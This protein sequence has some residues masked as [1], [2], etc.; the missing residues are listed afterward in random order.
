MPFELS[1]AEEMA[2]KIARE[3]C[4]KYI[5][6]RRKELMTNDQDMWDEEA[7]RQTRAGLHL[8]IVPREEGGTGIGY[9]ASCITIEELCAAWPDL[10]FAIY[11]EFAYYFAK[12]TGGDVY[13]KYMPGILKGDIL[14]TP[15]ITEPS[16]GSDMLGLQ[17]QAKKVDGGWV[18]NGRKV[19][20]SEGHYCDFVMT[21][22]KT[23]DPNDPKTPGSRS[24]TAFIVDKEFDGFRVGRLENT[25]GRKSDLT[26]FIFDNVFV[27]DNFVVGGEKGV[28]RGIAPVFSAV[29]DIGRLTICGMLNGISAGSYRTAMMYAKERHLYGRPISE[30]QMIQARIAKMVVDLEAT[31]ALTYRAA[32]L[33]TK[34]IRADAEQATAKNFAEQAAIRI[35]EHCVK[36]HGGYGVLEDYMPHHYYRHVPMRFGA[37]GTEESLGIMIA[38]AAFRNEANP[39]L[40]HNSMETAGWWGRLEW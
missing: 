22:F 11:G 27:P 23:G 14:A 8:H 18:L 3:Y 15:A 1:P 35:A 4:E 32:W 21:L 31:R 9:V 16:G 19:F 33:R 17:A 2:R 20:Q 34:G 29:G 28:G 26:E 12:A 13:D 30:L 40:S 36:I 6:P 7:H 25:L 24:L 10:A 38:N 5:I 37:G 39:D